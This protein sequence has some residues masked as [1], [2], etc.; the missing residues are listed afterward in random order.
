MLNEHFSLSDSNA[1]ERRVGQ[2]TT[3]RLLRAVVCEKMVLAEVNSF[4]QAM[5]LK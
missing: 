1:L 5:A 3:G 2:Q 4:A